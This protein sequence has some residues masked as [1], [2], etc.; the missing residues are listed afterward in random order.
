MRY[1]IKKSNITILIF[2]QVIKI[3][4]I[5]FLAPFHHPIKMVE[6]PSKIKIF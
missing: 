2:F 4:I 5:K 1:D 3:I 6:S